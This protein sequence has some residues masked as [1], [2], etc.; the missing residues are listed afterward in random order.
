MKIVTHNDRFHADDVCAMATLRICFG[1]K[2]TEII[3]TRDESIIQTADIVFDVGHVYNPETNRFDHHQTEGAGKRENGIPYAA[4]GLVWKKFGEE[5]CGSKEVAYSIDKKMV[6]MVD[7][8]DNGMFPYT[9]TQE[10]LRE[11]VLDTICHS[12]GSTWKEKD[13]YDGGFFQMVDMVEKILRREIKV[14]QDKAEAIPFIEKTYQESLDK[15]IIVFD[16]YYPWGDTLKKYSDIYFVVSP[17]KEKDQ[18]RILTI[19]DQ[20]L[21]NKKSL[22]ASWGG[23]KGEELEK[24]TG[25]KGSRFCHKALFMAVADTKEVAIKLAKIALES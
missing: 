11:Y 5:I 21:K 18:W 15:Q 24:V 22:P 14:A 20:Q 3:R 1:D 12:F 7:A 19:Q 9:Y 17:T 25:I 2:I 13:N 6:Q 4:F 16:E 8:S 23:L 10:D